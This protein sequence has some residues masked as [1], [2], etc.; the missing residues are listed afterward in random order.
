MISSIKIRGFRGFADE[1][2]LKLAKPNGNRGSGL[3][4]IVGPN[5]G[6]KSTIIESFKL[7]SSGNDISFAEGQRNKKAGDSVEIVLSSYNEGPKYSLKTVSAGSYKA[8]RALGL[9]NGKPHEPLITVLSS[10]RFF[11]PYS[12]EASHGEGIFFTARPESITLKARGQPIDASDNGLFKIIEDQ[13]RSAEFNKILKQIIGYELKWTV[14]LCNTGEYYIKINDNHDSDGLGEGLVSLLFLVDSLFESSENELIVIDEPE[15][16]LHPELQRNLLNLILDYSKN[17]QIL[18]ATHSPEM[19][20]IDAVING[21]TLARVI[22]PECSGSKIYNISLDDKT[23][24]FLKGSIQNRNNPHIFA[25]DARSCFFVEDSLVVVEGQEDV[26]LLN[27]ALDLLDIK[28]KIRFF[29]FGAGGAENIK[30]IVTI[31]SSLGYGNICCLYDGDKDFEKKETEKLFPKENF[32][33]YDFKLLNAKD[34]RDKECIIRNKCK[35]IKDENKCKG[36]EYRKKGIMCC[37]SKK[38]NNITDENEC[39]KC[40]YGKQGIFDTDENIK[41]DFKEEFESLLKEIAEKYGY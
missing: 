3:T 4:I 5:N 12:K 39:K 36:C 24:K 22:N 41:A 8:K 26:V 27:K 2:E 20:S 34:I 25:Y 10:R 38:C 28:K 29:G 13:K 17:I 30:H 14:D 19:V 37:V 16:S 9:E 32:P 18:Y 21:G 23:K 15:M 31:L 7:M 33:N 1:Q 11:N 6:G 40:K 35:N